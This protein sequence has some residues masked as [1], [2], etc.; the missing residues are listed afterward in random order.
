MAVH[1]KSV[2]PVWKLVR[3]IEASGPG[4]GGIPEAHG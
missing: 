4:H 3:N 2:N 1:G